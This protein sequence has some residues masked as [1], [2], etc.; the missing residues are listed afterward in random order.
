MVDP[1]AVWHLLP[2]RAS[3][4]KPWHVPPNVIEIKKS[5][6]IAATHAPL[7]VL[8]IHGLD[9]GIQYPFKNV[10]SRYLRLLP[11]VALLLGPNAI[12]FFE[13]SSLLGAF[14]NSLL[15]DGCQMLES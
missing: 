9:E 8:L 4:M 2:S 13:Y 3:W 1:N 10:L 14:G 5:R 12:I 15:E 11:L 6:I 7:D